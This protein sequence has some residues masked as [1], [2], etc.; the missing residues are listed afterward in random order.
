M[1]KIKRQQKRTIIFSSALT[2]FFFATVSPSESCGAFDL[3]N[4]MVVYSNPPEANGIYPLTT[5]A[6]FTC[7]EGF[8]LVG[9]S[10]AYCFSDFS[11][12]NVWLDFDAFDFETEANPSCEGN[13][14]KYLY[15]CIFLKPSCAV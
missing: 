11:G 6:D 8:T 3:P 9:A 10:R 4:C 5:F 2:V 12:F 13:K 15:Y 1:F 7:N 14:L